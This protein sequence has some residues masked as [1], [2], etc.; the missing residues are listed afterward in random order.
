MN[1]RK[2]RKQFTVEIRMM[3]PQLLHLEL[4]WM[5][6]II[7]VIIH[8]TNHIIIII[9]VVVNMMHRWQLIWWR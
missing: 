7:I 4:S 8:N 1:G 6:M 2:N 5:M 9:I 3:S